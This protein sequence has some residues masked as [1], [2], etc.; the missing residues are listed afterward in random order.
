M[1]PEEF[2]RQTPPRAIPPRLTRPDPWLLG[3]SIL[4]TVVVLWITLEV[5]HEI[6]HQIFVIATYGLLIWLFFMLG[7]RSQL[8][9]RSLLRYGVAIKGIVSEHGIKTRELPKSTVN[10]YY[11]E[12]TF[13][14]GE[15]GPVKQTV[16]ETAW[17][18]L[19]E[20]TTVN[21]LYDPEGKNG[22][23]LTD[24]LKLE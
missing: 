22:Y 16:P 1:T 6:S 13:P 12:V 4:L 20:S 8:R 14:D 11:V 15:M 18:T 7:R 24:I 17:Y 5:L 10:F 21:V 2:C 19:T 3:G 9:F 23:L